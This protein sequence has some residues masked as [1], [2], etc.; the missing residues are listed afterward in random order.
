MGNLNFYFQKF[1]DKMSGTTIDT[2]TDWV[3]G[4]GSGL[5]SSDK[6]K[7]L[8]WIKKYLRNN[9]KREVSES[10]FRQMIR[11]MIQDVLK[12]EEEL[13]EMSSV[14][15]MAG[16]DAYNTPFAFAGDSEKNKKLK[17]QMIRR[18]NPDWE[19]MWD[20][21]EKPKKERKWSV[22]LH[23]SKDDEIAKIYVGRDAYWLK[24]HG[25]TTHFYISNTPIKPNQDNWLYHV[26]QAKSEPY[27]NDLVKWL[28]G[29]EIDGKKYKPNVKSSLTSNLTE[30]TEKEYIIW[31]I[32]PGKSDEDILYTKA[33][34]P[35]EAK[36]ICGILE[37]E[38]GCKKCR[39]QTLDL[40]VAPDFTKVF[41]EFITEGRRGAYHDY[42]DDSN[43]TTRQKI[44]Q[45]VREIYT[46]LKEIE[47]R[48]DMNLRL[49]EETG[50]N[51]DKYWS[52]TRKSFARV[53]EV[54]NRILYKMKQF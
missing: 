30:K 47:R 22:E 48:I 44:G 43:L 13:E 24:K 9:P 21:N 3:D 38:H 53:N 27:Y 10:T 6:K 31:G 28:R 39:V 17:T 7:L 5:S 18:A 29:G 34:S 8:V 26:N 36:K 37:K 54:M 23:E 42:R 40:S 51:G 20:D 32:P 4:I 11:D 14:T 15:G 12:N 46:E 16:G 2:A 19:E 25:D 45:S 52:R 33:K 1:K 50:I 41:N 49:K 35:S